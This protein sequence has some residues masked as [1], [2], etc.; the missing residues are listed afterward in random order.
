MVALCVALF[1][2]LVLTG[3][4]LIL[5]VHP[6]HSPHQTNPPHVLAPSTPRRAVLRE[7]RRLRLLP[8][9]LHPPRKK[10]R[11]LRLL[12]HQ[13]DWIA[14]VIEDVVHVTSEG[15]AVDGG[16]GDA[17]GF[18]QGR[19]GSGSAYARDGAGEFSGGE[20][21]GEGGG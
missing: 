21:E 9:L 12:V 5:L 3:K 8:L 14:T 11:V 6:L 1:V 10:Q 7:Q 4:L 2:A 18:Y 13:E 15:T 17:G 19:E 20:G 16:A